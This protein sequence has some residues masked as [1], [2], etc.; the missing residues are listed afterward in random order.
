MVRERPTRERLLEAA[1][2]AIEAGGEVSVRVD[3]IAAAAG[4]TKPMIY[5]HFVERDGLIVAAQAERYR[6]ALA[7]GLSEMAAAVDR[8]GSAEDYA[9]LMRSWVRSFADADGMR[10]RAMRVEVLGSAVSR[11]GLR[12]AIRDVTAAHVAQLAATIT[13]A[14]QRGWVTTQFSAATFAAWWTGLVLSRHT[15]ETHPD[16]YDLDAWDALTATILQFVS[17]S[18]DWPEPTQAP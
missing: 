3:R 5:A 6:R 15:V 1:I 7:F 11:P 18:G 9:A 17:T 8:C 13:T 4:V 2:D 16:D 12:A 10:R 14:Q